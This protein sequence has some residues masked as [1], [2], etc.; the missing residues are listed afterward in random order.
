MIRDG[1]DYCYK[2]HQLVHLQVF[3]ARWVVSF[4]VLFCYFFFASYAYLL[5]PDYDNSKAILKVN[6]SQL[7]PENSTQAN[8]NL[9]LT[10]TKID[11]SWISFTHFL[12]FFTVGNSNP[13]ITRTYK[14]PDR[15]KKSAPQSELLKLP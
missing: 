3:H 14:A 11:F 15:S 4:F 7:T 1:E 5:E 9:A 2:T 12:L 6:S 8:S 13:P 10:R